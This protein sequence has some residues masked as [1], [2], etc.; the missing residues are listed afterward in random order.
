MAISL[1]FHPTGFVSPTV[2]DAMGV[3]WPPNDYTDAPSG[4]YTF[5]LAGTT[6]ASFVCVV[7]DSPYAGTAFV[8]Q[9][10]NIA[11][12]NAENPGQPWTFRAPA[13]REIIWSTDMSNGANGWWTDGHGGGDAR[14]YI[15]WPD[16]MD[17][18]G[19]ALNVAGWR[20]FPVARNN[21]GF[22]ASFFSV[23]ESAQ[24]AMQNLGGVFPI[25]LL[26]IGQTSPPSSPVES[27]GGMYLT[28]SDCAGGWAGMNNQFVAYNSAWSPNWAEFN[29]QGKVV[30]YTG[31]DSGWEQGLYYVNGGNTL[32]LLLSFA[33]SSGPQAGWFVGMLDGVLQNQPA[34][35]VNGDTYG[36]QAGATGAQ[37]AGNDGAIA[38]YLDGAWTFADAIAMGAYLALPQGD[39]NPVVYFSGGRG[40][41]NAWNPLDVF[42][43]TIPDQQM[44]VQL[45]PAA[46]GT[47][48]FALPLPTTAP[49]WLGVTRVVAWLTAAEHLAGDC[50]IEIGTTSSGSE[51][52]AA[53]TLTGLTATAHV[54]RKAIPDG[55]T[56]VIGNMG[57][58]P[59]TFVN[60][61]VTVVQADSGSGGTPSG[62]LMVRLDCVPLV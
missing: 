5:P 24:Y 61:Y 42:L 20:P 34:S 45:N 12:Y 62:T 10:S 6:V 14:H 43:S 37:W 60:A 9:T 21:A 30:Q 38:T 51:I 27:P 50:V 59:P 53:T 31:S 8:G 35:P 1:P 52:L 39:S 4:C 23:D 33:N 26:S 47:T 17:P 16:S 13:P 40:P 54:F 36:V 7:G 2:V 48:P 29:A 46:T 11:T 18:Y 28:G 57:G 49:V 41:G 3:N 19:P 55:V 44:V 15:Y 22:G 25:P 32:L 58:A 56:P